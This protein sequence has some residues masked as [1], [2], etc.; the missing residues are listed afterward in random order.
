[1][2][3][4]ELTRRDTDQDGILKAREAEQAKRNARMVSPAKASSD[5]YGGVGWLVGLLITLFVSAPLIWILSRAATGS[6]REQIIT[7]GIALAWWA[8]PLSLGALGYVISNIRA[9]KF[10]IIA[11]GLVWFVVNTL[12]SLSILSEVARGLII[13]GLLYIFYAVLALLFLYVQLRVFIWAASGK[14]GR[15]FFGIVGWAALNG[16]VYWAIINPEILNIVLV[17]LGFVFRILFAISFVVIQ[18]VAIFWFMAQSRVEVI[19]PGDP[20]QL[21]FDDYKGQPNLLKL[22]RQ[23]IYLLSDRGKFQ[24]MGGQFING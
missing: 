16:V 7:I 12:V 8:N 2:S 10:W 19:R 4:T 3:T 20:K 22:V 17:L 9:W 15:F 24:K 23:W 14:S 1:M 6:V 21:T 18:F 11:G 13:T 5:F